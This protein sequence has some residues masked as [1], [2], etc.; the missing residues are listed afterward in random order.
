M[1]GYETQSVVNTVADGTSVETYSVREACGEDCTTEPQRCREVCKS[2]SN[3]FATCRQ[4]CSGGG[5][6]CKPRY[7]SGTR[8]REVP[9]TRSE[10]VKIRVP[11]YRDEPRF[12]D[13]FSYTTWSWAH[14]RTVREQGALLGDDVE[15]GGAKLRWPAGARTSGL[16]PGQQER[17]KRTARYRVA[18]VYGGDSTISF[19]VKSPEAFAAFTPGSHHRLRIEQGSYIVNASA[20]TPLNIR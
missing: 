19:E 18:L 17:E 16:P 4:V 5:R 20:V 3:G 2:N 9:R 1:T 8:T 6:K 14:D 11:T 12:A 7:C 13:A 15:A 10:V